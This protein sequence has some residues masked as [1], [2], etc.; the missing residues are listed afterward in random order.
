[1]L[2]LISIVAVVATICIWISALF[3]LNDQP[4]KKPG[5]IALAFIMTIVTAAFIKLF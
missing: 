2:D 5:L 1:M 3:L 4:S